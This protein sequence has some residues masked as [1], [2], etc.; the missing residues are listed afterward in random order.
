MGFV[1]LGK[2]KENA[3]KMLKLQLIYCKFII[4]I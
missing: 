4:T 1:I 2:M 3:R